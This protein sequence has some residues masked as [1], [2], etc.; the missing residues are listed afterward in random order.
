VSNGTIKIANKRFTSIPNDYCISF[1][2]GTEFEEVEDDTAIGKHG[3]SF[4]PVKELQ[5]LINQSVDVVGVILEV[6]PL[7]SITLRSDGSQ[8]DKR[9]ITLADETNTSISCTLWNQ[10]AHI[11][12]LEVGTF[13]AMKNARISEYQGCSMNS[14]ND[15]AD[16][17]LN[18]QHPRVQQLR[19]WFSSRSLQDHLK[20]ISPLTQGGAMSGGDGAG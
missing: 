8:K 5:T 16:V 13:I 14:S 1:N 7:G 4:R 20:E 11:E 17:K 10:A 9:N 19:K 15:T 3:F 18:I 2:E 6:G 12:E